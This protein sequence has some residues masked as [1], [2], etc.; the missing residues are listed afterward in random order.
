MEEMMSTRVGA[1]TERN[2]IM[3]LKSLNPLTAAYSQLFPAVL[4]DIWPSTTGSFVRVEWSCRGWNSNSSGPCALV[5]SQGLSFL[6]FSSIIQLIL[7]YLSSN[8]PTDWRV[9]GYFHKL[10]AR[11]KRRTDFYFS[12]LHKGTS[13]KT[14][15]VSVHYIGTLGIGVDLK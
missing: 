3:Y 8:L 10:I 14:Y 11:L 9:S 6:P 1:E 2:R 5:H 12:E 4:A 13:K 15:I 7:P